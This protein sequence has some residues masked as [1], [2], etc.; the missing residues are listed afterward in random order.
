MTT[1][2]LNPKISEVEKKIPDNS[3]F[4][5]TQEVIKLA[6]ENFASRLK[7]ADLVNKTDFDDNKLRGFNR[8]T[9]SQT[10]RSSKEIK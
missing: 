3:K 8:Q 7:Q 1:S 6:S 10:L 4:I 9:T 2:V 5:T